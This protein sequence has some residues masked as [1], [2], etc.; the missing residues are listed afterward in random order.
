MRCISNAIFKVI[1]YPIYVIFSIRRRRRQKFPNSRPPRYSHLPAPPPPP[2]FHI[3][4]DMQN[5]AFDARRSAVNQKWGEFAAR[6]MVDK[7]KIPR[8]LLKALIEI[9]PPR[10]HPCPNKP[11]YHETGGIAMYRRSIFYI[12]QYYICPA[13]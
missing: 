4:M 1:L 13:F 10:V 9:P 2:R 3:E 5:S 7:D 6:H 11:L 12:L 8:F